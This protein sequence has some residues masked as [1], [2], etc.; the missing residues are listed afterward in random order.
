MNTIAER[1]TQARIDA[2]FDRREDAVSRFG[3][4]YP[5]YSAHENGSRGVKKPDILKYAKAFGVSSEWLLFGKGD[6]NVTYDLPSGTDANAAGMAEAAEPY[7]PPT[8][9]MRLDLDRLGRHFAAGGAHITT[10]QAARDIPGFSVLRGD[11][12]LIDLK[13]QT[14]ATGQLAL[15][16]L[17]NGSGGRTEIM[18]QTRRG[19]TCAFGCEQ[20]RK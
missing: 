6:L 3:W 18:M 16:Q 4:K 1:L 19:L 12:L 13:N 17:A 10:Y 14:P 5:T 7:L 15:A 9:T 8:D 20:P 11:I 2:G